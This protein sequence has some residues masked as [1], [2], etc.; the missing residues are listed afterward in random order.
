[1]NRKIRLTLRIE[2]NQL[3]C[4]ILYIF[5]GLRELERE[6]KTWA[7]HLLPL[8]SKFKFFQKSYQFGVLICD[9]EKNY[10]PKNSAPKMY[11]FFKYKYS[12][13]TKITFRRI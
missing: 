11:L 5:L 2:K 10:Q 13:N 9:T 7:G 12:E 6:K 3:K 8:F 4:M 1:M